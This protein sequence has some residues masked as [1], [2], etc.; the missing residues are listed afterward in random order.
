[1]LFKAKIYCIISLLGVIMFKKILYILIIFSIFSCG[2]AIK[3]DAKQEGEQKNKLEL[4]K[5]EPKELKKQKP[6]EELKKQKPKKELKKQEPTWS[7]KPMKDINYEE[8]WK[9]VKKLRNE[10]M[11]KSA[12]EE[13][14]K[15]YNL[16]KLNN[17]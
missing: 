11:N 7:Y 15:I 10:G 14:E 4:K 17:N 9:K 8:N 2:N 6:K 1:M 12:Y 3:N 5:Q 16:A 13:V